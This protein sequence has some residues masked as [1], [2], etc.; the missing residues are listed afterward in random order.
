[1]V[2]EVH[3]SQK[4]KRPDAKTANSWIKGGEDHQPQHDARIKA[5]QAKNAALAP[6]VVRG[7]RPKLFEEDTERLNVML[8]ASM[9]RWVK[10][11][12]L[13][14]HST[15]GQILAGLIIAVMKK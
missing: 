11:K 5:V 1:M 9:V 14:G 3:V 7:G 15:P 8:P 10:Q 13:D 2:P 6:A 12:A 4:P